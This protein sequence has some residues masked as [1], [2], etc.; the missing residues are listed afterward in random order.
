[1]KCLSVRQPWAWALLHAGKDV[2]NRTWAPSPKQLKPG[3]RLAIHAS[4]TFDVAG[5]RWICANHEALGLKLEDIPIDPKAYA[6]GCV[7]GSVE[8]VGD[9]CIELYATAPN[10][11]RWAFGP[12]CWLVKNPVALA[13]PVPMKGKLMLFEVPDVLD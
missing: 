12:R 2:E 8:F 13:E 11:G 6:V 7:V 3:E 1:M 9:I 4:K 10:A 5:L